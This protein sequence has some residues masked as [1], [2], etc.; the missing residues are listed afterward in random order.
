MSDQD[1]FQNVA[2]VV[3]FYGSRAQSV[4]GM[5]TSLTRVFTSDLACVKDRCKRK[6]AQH[7]TS[8]ASAEI[9]LYAKASGAYTDNITAVMQP[10]CSSS[11][12]YKMCDTIHI[13]IL[14]VKWLQSRQ[15]RYVQRAHSETELRRLYSS[16]N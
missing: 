10:F 15:S 3:R 11:K 9:P 7:K 5:N 16:L 12:C 1:H 6:Q 8:F 2:E 14:K 13:H 4:R